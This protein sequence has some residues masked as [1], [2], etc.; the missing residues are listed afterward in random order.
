MRRAILTTF[1][2][3][4]VHFTVNAQN[5]SFFLVETAAL[6][7]DMPWEMF[8][9]EF[10]PQLGI[11]FG[12]GARTSLNETLE[13]SG[14]LSYSQKGFLQRVKPSLGL[15]SPDF[16]YLW[17]V[18]L[19]FVE[20]TLLLRQTLVRGVVSPFV[21]AGP[22]LSHLYNYLSTDIDEGYLLKTLKRNS[23]NLVVG[24]GA[25]TTL[26]HPYRVSIGVRYER[27]LT[28]IDTFKSS[29]LYHR[30]LALLLGVAI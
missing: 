11:S 19:D 25:E 3:V 17:R 18:D 23:W 7:S 15:Y 20:T 27:G 5:Q 10:E 6:R 14:L 4:F 12:V 16:R 9:G 30:T 1:A 21:E 2:V 26:L 24:F 28:D 22:R 8:T 13:L 29:S